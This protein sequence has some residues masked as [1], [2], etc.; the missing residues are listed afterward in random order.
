MRSP[1]FV[2]GLVAIIF[3]AGTLALIHGCED[4]SQP[5][6]ANPSLSVILKTLTVTGSGTGNGVVTSSPTGINCTITAGVAGSTGC[7][8]Q[9]SSTTTVTLTATPKA[10]HSFVGWLQTCSGTGTCRTLMSVNRTVQAKFLKGPFTIRITSTSGTGSGRIKSQT[11]L[12]PAINCLITNGVPAAT[13]C[14]ATYP[15][16]TNVTLA[17]IPNSGFVF[18]GWREPSCGTG[19]CQITVIQARSIPATFSRVPS[20]TA[21]EQGRWEPVFNTPVVAVH[22]HLLSINKV[23]LWGDTGDPQLWDQTNGFAPVLKPYRIYCSG[24]TFTPDGRLLVTGGTSPGTR[25]LRIATVF[26]PSTKTW[27]ATSAMAQGRYYP[28]TTT[29]PNG[30]IL[31]VSGHDTNKTVVTI[32]EIWNGSGWRRL[33][34]APLAIPNPYYPPMF[35]APN[36]KVFY[37]GWTNPSRYLDVLGAGQ[38]TTVSARNMADRK[39]GSA[40]MYEPGKILYVG[41]GDTLQAPT[42][43]AEVIDLNDLTPSWTPVPAMHFP[44]RQLNATLLADG[45]VLVTGGTSGVGFNNQAG[46][47]HTPELWNPTNKSWTNMAPESRNRTYHSTAILLPSGKVLSTGSGEGGGVPYENSEFSAQLF[48]PPYL[49]NS[50]G[51][52]APRPSITSAPATLSYKQAFTV[53]TPNAAAISRGTLIRLSSVTHGFNQSQLIYPLIFTVSNSTT[54]SGTAPDRASLAPP[55]PYMLFLINKSGVPS[56]AKFVRIGS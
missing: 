5:V 37:A 20:T 45:S 21:A 48:S 15:A 54:L 22:V 29:L 44:R 43:S 25:G 17:A 51:T 10:G 52:L 35:V 38:W 18:N 34:A 3:S 32:P 56:T 33:T 36:G 24:H 2:A 6:E 50:D 26:N 9:F 19:S 40:V 55:G 30:E 23:L 42:P 7:Q 16:Y 46:A 49:F 41:G 14:S 47:V 27:T 28:T 8:K 1:R 13:G 31:A 4:T 11:G 12:T 39:L 53:Q